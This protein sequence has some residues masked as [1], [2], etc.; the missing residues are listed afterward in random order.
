MVTTVN[1]IHALGL[2]NGRRNAAVYNSPALELAEFIL[3]S[4]A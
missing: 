4:D 3:C 1:A 2:N